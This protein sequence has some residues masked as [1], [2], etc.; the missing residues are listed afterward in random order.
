[1][2]EESRSYL[3]QSS[4]EREFVSICEALIML[5]IFDPSTSNSMKRIK[6]KTKESR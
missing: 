6:K 2:F 3:T 4:K 5:E 1:M